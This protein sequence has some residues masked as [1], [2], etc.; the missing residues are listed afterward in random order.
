MEGRLAALERKHGRRIVWEIMFAL[1]VLSAAVGLHANVTR[2][3]VEAKEFVVV[4]E[5]G[6]P[7]AALR[8][9]EHGPGLWLFDENGEP[10]AVLHVGEDQTFLSMEDP[11]G[12]SQI[13]LE[14]GDGPTALSMT[15]EVDKIRVLLAISEKGPS[16]KLWEKHVAQPWS[17]P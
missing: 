14:V 15:D 5:S 17:A 12:V 9:S 3:V 6:E 16:L 2:D 4:S 8:L 10:R 11:A 13:S 7:R 1:A